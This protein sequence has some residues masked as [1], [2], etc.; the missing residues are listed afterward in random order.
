MLVISMMSILNNVGNFILF[1]TVLFNKWGTGSVIQY[2]CSIPLQWLVQHLVQVAVEH[3]IVITSILS[4]IFI[5]CCQVYIYRLQND[6]WNLVW[7]LSAENDPTSA[8][9][10]SLS[11]Y[12]RTLVI[13]DHGRGLLS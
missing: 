7:T 9:G 12:N 13:G 1:W 4:L 5:R 11:L 2:A 8:F 10:S 6:Q 3:V